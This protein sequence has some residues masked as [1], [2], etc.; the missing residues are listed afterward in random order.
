MALAGR[1]SRQTR[2]ITVAIFAALLVARL[3]D[4]LSTSQPAG[5]AAFVVALFILP[6]LYT[7]PAARRL[8]ERYRWPVL[9]GQ[10]VLSFVPYAV[11]GAQWTQGVT[12][13][14]AALVLLMLPGR[15]SWP[16]AG[17]LLLADLLLRA[18]PVGLPWA[19]AW[20]GALWVA[21]VFVD[22]CLAVFGLIR[23]ADLVGQVQTAQAEVAGLA[24]ARER[25]QA[26]TDLQVA[27]G[28]RLASIAGLAA[29]AQQALA[30][31]AA[32]AREH[33]V[34]AGV[35][36]RE[37]VARARAVLTGQRPPEALT[38][39]AAEGPGEE[40]AGAAVAP[41]LAWVIVVVLLCGFE[42][43]T[44]NNLYLDHFPA[45]TA[46]ASVLGSLGALVLQLYHS[47][48]VRYGGRP[49][50]WPVTLAI[51]TV[52]V[53]LPFMLTPVRFTGGLVPF[54]AG[55][56]LLLVPGWWRWAGYAGVVATWTVLFAVVPQ[57][58][59]N[60]P[61]GY[62]DDLY[63]LAANAGVGLLVYALT[64]LAEA[65]RQ[66]AGLRAELTGT[67]T[68]AE[69][70]RVARDVHDLLGLGLSA[71]ALKT[72]LVARLIGRD[73]GR[74]A[75][76]ITETSRLCAATRADIRLVTD[77]SHAQSLAAECAAARDI[78]SSAGVTV[79]LDVRA[80]GPGAA[81]SVLAPVLRE[82]VTNILRHSAATSCTI[83]A[84]ASGG[85][86]R[87]EISNDGVPAAAAAASPGGGRGLANLAARLHAAGGRLTAGQHG[88]R[89]EL[90]AEIPV[91]VPA[92]AG[93]R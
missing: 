15:L 18:G 50:A 66:L 55:S 27:L 87:L 89:F 53:F 26:A 28:E 36:A 59:P 83:R 76:E 81:D 84:V 21:V 65:A 9:A 8:I 20:S 40:P 80:A 35:T 25:Q 54:A 47:W 11:F 43:Q 17:L 49:R 44:L 32:A 38:G 71:I 16:L 22:D 93:S 57:T 68:A 30:S 13:L 72:D 29:A 41:R 45:G 37:A 58:G 60:P 70:L 39:A 73:D 67:A 48:G 75:A 78:L 5:Q 90:S 52:L 51:Q 33:I 7:V 69:R 82:A 34:A 23:L 91:P 4:A 3:A 19:P 79:E 1:A 88:G 56:F 86:L 46:V 62:V 24:V 12:G 77:A 92:P 14:L 6:F 64:W 74:A 10:A 85:L 61:P 31:D 63:V 42:A 2:A